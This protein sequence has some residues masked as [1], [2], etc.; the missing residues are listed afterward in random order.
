MMRA[1]RLLAIGYWLLRR[2]RYH[3]CMRNYLHG[4]LLLA[5]L[6]AAGCKGNRSTPSSTPRM[7]VSE[8]LPAKTNTVEDPYLWLEDVTGDKALDWVRQKNAVST[9]ELQARPD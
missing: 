3:G 9:R 4:A 7:P 8:S 5:A 2:R 6:L 1:P